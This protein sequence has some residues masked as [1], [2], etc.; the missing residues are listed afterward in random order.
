MKPVLPISSMRTEERDHNTT[1]E[2]G[3]GDTFDAA[4]D[5]QPY[6]MDVD[7]FRRYF[8][9]QWQLSQFW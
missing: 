4:D 9:E 5:I 8:G 7:G 1:L 2:G 3:E 6:Q